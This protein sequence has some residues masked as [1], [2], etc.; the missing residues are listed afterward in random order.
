MTTAF[1]WFVRGRLDRS[2]HANPSGCLLALGAVPVLAWLIA[3]AVRNQPLGFQ[4]LS[5]PMVGL[6]VVALVV[7]VVCWLV[8]LVVSPADLIPTGVS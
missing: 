6:L 7:C 1:A 3:S 2:W 8:R 5:G 4:S